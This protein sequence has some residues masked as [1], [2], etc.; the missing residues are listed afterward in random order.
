[1]GNELVRCLG[2]PMRFYVVWACD[3]FR[4]DRADF[5]RDQIGVGEV[6]DAYRTIEP[7]GNEINEAIAVAGLDMKLG[8]TVCH[9]REHGREMG[10][11][12]RQRRRDA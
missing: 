4:V 2:C 3:E 11:A 9:L 8:V 7:L 1:M 6:S 10:R 5:P 12:K